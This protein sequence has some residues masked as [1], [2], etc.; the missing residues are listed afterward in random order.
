MKATRMHKDCV[1]NTLFL[2]FSYKGV[3]QQHSQGKIQVQQEL[4]KTMQLRDHT[5]KSTLCTHHCL[6]LRWQGAAKENIAASNAEMSLDYT[7]PWVKLTHANA[8]LDNDFFGSYLKRNAFLLP[9]PPSTHSKELPKKTKKILRAKA[10]FFFVLNKT[11]L[12]NA[13]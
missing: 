10:K 4:G 8:C 11:R 5:D 9:L 3:Q 7:Y 1:L 6:R 13:G 12:H 2:K